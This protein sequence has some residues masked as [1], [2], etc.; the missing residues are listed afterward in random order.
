M[1][2]VHIKHC[3]S[4]NFMY[5]YVS[6]TYVHACEIDCELTLCGYGGRGGDRQVTAKTADT[7]VICMPLCCPSMHL[8]VVASGQVPDQSPRI[9]A[10]DIHMTYH[11]YYYMSSANA[12][13]MCDA[14]ITVQYT[15][16]KWTDCICTCKITCM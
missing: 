7:A 16:R 10:S 2:T 3:M 14:T 6:C 9:S 8:Q 11:V 5:W 1:I 15:C 12:I 13:C 4:M